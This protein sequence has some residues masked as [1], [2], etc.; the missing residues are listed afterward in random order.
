MKP[1]RLIAQSLLFLNISSAALAADVVKANNATALDTATSWTGGNLPTS[2][3]IAVFTNG[4]GTTASIGTGITLAGLRYTN[5]AAYNITVGTGSLSVGSSGIDMTA[6]TANHTISSPLSLGANQQWNI[7]S[8]RTLTISG[9]TGFNQGTNSVS[10]NGIG[11]VTF[12]PTFGTAANTTANGSFIVNGGVLLL[13]TGNTTGFPSLTNIISPLTPLSLGGGTF[14]ATVGNSVGAYTQTLGGLTITSGAS[15]ATQARGSSSSVIVNFGAISRNVG[16]SLN[17]TPTSNNSGFRTSTANV[18][19]MQSGG[20]TLNGTD[21]AQATNATTNIGAATYVADIW[22]TTNKT[23][24]TVDSSQSGA[25]THSLRFAA[26]AARTLTLSGINTI[27]S[28]GLL[29]S[30][31]VGANNN[32][33]TGGSLRGSVGGDLIV[34]QHSATGIL[35]IASEIADN[36]TATALTKTGAGTLILSG[37]NTFTGNLFL[38]AGT[39]QLANS[40]AI[41]T[42]NPNQVVFANNSSAKLQLFGNNITLAAVNTSQ[43]LAATLPVI[44]NGGTV[45]SILTVNNVDSCTFGGTIQNGSTGRL[46]LTKTNVGT[47]TLSGT[48]S[49]AGPVQISAG[50]LALAGNASLPANTITIDSGATLDLSARSGGGLSLTSTQTLAGSG[51]VTGAISTV[52]GSKLVPGANGNIGTMTLSTLNLGDSSSV[53]FELAGAGTSADTISVTTASGL[54][55]GNGILVNLSPTSGGQFANGIGNTYTLFQYGGTLSG[56]GTFDGTITPG[57]FSV[58]NPVGGLTY[59]FQDTGSAI[60]LTIGGSLANDATWQ[61]SQDLSWNNGANWSTGT[62]PQS[63]GDSARFG[64]AIGTTPTSINLDGTKTV[65]LLEINSSQASYTITAGSG[66]GIVLNNGS[67]TGQITLTAGNHAI[68][69]PVTLSSS[70]LCGINGASDSLTLSAELGGVGDLTKTGAGLLHL[71]GTST[72]SGAINL[73]A[74]TTSFVIGALGTSGALNFG[75]GTLQF[76]SGNTEDISIIRTTSLLVGGGAFDTNGNEVELAGSL[77]G[78]GDLTKKGAGTLTLSGSNAYSG[79]TRIEAGTLKIA[80]NTNLGTTPATATPGN[81]SIGSAALHLH[82]ALTLPAN[83]GLALTSPSSTIVLADTTASTISGI[84]TGT[85]KL[86]LSGAGFLTLGGANTHSGGNLIQP[87]ALVTVNSAAAL[88]TG[89]TELD[90]SQLTINVAT[91]TF[92]NIFVAEGNTGIVDGGVQQRPGISG[93]IGAGDVTFFTRSGGVNAGSNAF[94]F[95]LQGSYSGFSGILRLKSAVTETTHSFPLHFNGGGFNGDLSNARVILSDYARLCGINNSGGNAVNIGALSGDAT[96]ILAGADYAGTHTYN[97]GAKN[98]DTTFEGLITNGSAGNA[99]LIKSGTGTLTLT[100]ANTYLGTTTVNTGTLAITHATALGA[101]S[102]GTTISGGDVD[103]RLSVSGGLTITEPLTLGGR[104]GLNYDSPHILNVSG[105]N[106]LTTAAIVPATGG[107]SYNIQSDA[108]LLSISGSFTPSGAVTGSRYLQLFG[109]GN[110]EWLGAIQNGTAVVSVNKY[111]TGSWT[112]TGDLS[113]TGDT[114]VDAGSLILTST[115]EL[116]FKPTANGITNKIGGFGSVSLDGKFT[117]DLASA[118]ITNE[119]S[120]QLVD[121]NGLTETYGSNFSVTDFTKSGTDWIKVDGANTWTFSQTTGTLS[122]AVLTDPFIPWIGT[123]FPGETNASIIGKNADPD[124]D[125]LN[126]L[127]EFALNS[128]PSNAS[129]TGKVIGKVATLG[130]NQVMT[131]TLP[132]RAGATFTDDATT[133]EEVSGLIDGVIYRIQG[134]SNLS[135]WT[136]DVS[137]VASGSDRDAIQAGLPALD[138]GWSYRTFRAPGTVPSDASNFLRVKVTE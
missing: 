6:A 99:N 122:L 58:A 96:S 109:E 103:G 26:A 31:G 126:N 18:N 113:Y 85:G 21:F 72:H 53:D 41:N 98:L 135:A 133:H 65:A 61:G 10:M 37:N 82:A 48:N 30:S 74:G 33:I 84:I 104:Q 57:T 32:L 88:G 64:N 24:V 111:G 94:G 110:G 130:G 81:I 91:T 127:A 69:A 60:T 36:T 116:R 40:G 68:N 89:Q 125:G 128:N 62:V 50:T 114:N 2:S 17:L 93:L 7:G 92:N 73:N 107:N 20:I 79:N 117:I 11:N 78:A 34:H 8:G 28:G 15:V 38:N 112:L 138:T 118:N 59:T 131:L 105:T 66:G 132:V 43:V 35:T 44:E 121:V 83:R 22:A 23:N 129:T 87:G 52:L 4:S 42:S 115:S 86:N 97:I 39:L 5:A 136:L 71:N 77:Q 137:E 67:S 19:G 56:T 14:Q 80:A 3:D 108:G 106:Q 75:G 29:V 45:D 12:A 25:T 101:D 123:Y 134:S 102:N 1:R 9:T 76:A 54:V 90:D 120:W 13:S 16:G 119:N 95:R 47:L 51:T 63:V 100:A 27:S 124:N 49:S 70:T 46:G 55:L